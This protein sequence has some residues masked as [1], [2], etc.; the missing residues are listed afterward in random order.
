MGIK[1]EYGITKDIK[2]VEKEIADI[3]SRL[4]DINKW[5]ILWFTRGCL[6]TEEQL[7][8]DKN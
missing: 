3:I 5:R 7:E 4:V 2:E 6:K 8:R 1:C